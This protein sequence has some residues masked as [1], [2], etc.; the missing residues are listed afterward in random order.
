MGLVILA[1]FLAF[2]GW[3]IW[4]GNSGRARGGQI[5]EWVAQT[6]GISQGT[7]N[8]R[9]YIRSAGEV[10]DVTS[11]P[12]SGLV[13]VHSHDSSF[14]EPSLQLIVVQSLTAL[15]KAWSDGTP[16]YA[17]TVLDDGTYSQLVR[18]DL[19]PTQV[20]RPL[21]AVSQL[22]IIAAGCT[23]GTETIT[24]RAAVVSSDGTHAIDVTVERRCPTA[25]AWSGTPRVH[26]LTCGAP[27]PSMPTDGRC[28]SCGTALGPPPGSW[29]ITQLAGVAGG[30]DAS[31]RVQIEPLRPFG[32]HSRNAGVQAAA[33]AIA[34][35]AL[36]NDVLRRIAST[37]PEFRPDAIIGYVE[38]L[39]VTSIPA[40]R[41]GDPDQF[42]APVPR[43]I[44]LRF[45]QSH[46]GANCRSPTRVFVS[47]ADADDSTQYLTV[48]LEF[49][50]SFE[51]WG[52]SRPTGTKTR[53]DGGL[54][55]YRCPNCGGPLDVDPEERCRHCGAMSV[56][57][58]SDW[59]ITKMVCQ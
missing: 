56:S 48:A 50:Q 18:R 21:T 32:E 34:V 3:L 29:V 27:L 49:G 33:A 41:A 12:S 2:F 10:A 19:M 57:G 1:I 52:L 36:T 20:R 24:W 23:S 17:R 14:S 6:F 47:D 43:A 4:Y 31:G 51:Y 35:P 15:A 28:P 44:A 25:G 39:Y 16:G 54:L 45:M 42:P 55:A 40:R 7:V 13:L 30:I 26:C 37:D 9:Q 11:D 22:A 59:T 53:P 58:A 46:P 38:K 5:G 8:H